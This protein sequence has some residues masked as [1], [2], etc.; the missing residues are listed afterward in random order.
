[1]NIRVAT[2]EETLAY[3][4]VGL[5]RRGLLPPIAGAAIAVVQSRGAFASAAISTGNTLA[6]S[7]NVAAGN[8]LTVMGEIA[9]VAPGTI[10]V[11]DTRGTGYT[12][13]SFSSA[14]TSSTVYIAW[15][16]APT[17]GANTAAVAGTIA[18]VANIDVDIA[19][20]SGAPGLI[21]DGPNFTATGSTGTTNLGPTI[22]AS[23][24]G[25]LLLCMMSS[26][27]TGSVGAGWTNIPATVTNG[28]PSAYQA[29]GASGSYT[30][31]FSQSSNVAYAVIAIALG[32]GV[33]YVP[34]RMPLGV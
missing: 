33:P 22:V 14:N 24:A 32:T 25:D 34:R 11:T 6:Y 13:R 28:D 18:T 26:G 9:N 16:Y 3:G 23:V 15:G 27:S 17:G 19:E 4:R 30:T 20:F 7:S 29:A 31:A 12:V 21:Q 8:L 1:V 2:V 5:R 10:S